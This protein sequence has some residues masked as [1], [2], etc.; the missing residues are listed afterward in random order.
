MRGAD[1]GGATVQLADGSTV[2][3]SRGVIVAADGPAAV[4]LLG[5]ALV[6]E[7]PSKAEEGVGTSCV[8]FSC[9]FI[10]SNLSPVP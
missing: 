2:A 9:A 6:G 10:H 8:Y 1:G 4:R 3:A 7:S 5:A